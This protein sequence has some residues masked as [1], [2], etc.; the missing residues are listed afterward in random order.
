MEKRPPQ[1]EKRR[2]YWRVYA[3]AL[4]KGRSAVTGECTDVSTLIL[5][6]DRCR[7]MTLSEACNVLHVNEGD[8]DEL[9][10]SLVDALP[11]YIELC[12]GLKEAD[13]D[14]E[15]LVNVVSGFLL[16]QWYYADHADDQAL[17]RT[18]DA[19]FKA[20]SLKAREYNAESE[21]E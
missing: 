13:Q 6:K 8:N 15:P 18:I 14:E 4:G 10:E 1:T 16:T 9:I 3:A 5:K 17:T 21:T 11:A 7:K 2:S 20:L 19:L 12:T